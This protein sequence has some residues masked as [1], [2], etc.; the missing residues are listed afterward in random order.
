MS[1]AGL[2]ELQIRPE[3]TRRV[4]RAKEATRRWAFAS[5]SRLAARVGNER[6]TEPDEPGGVQPACVR[7]GGELVDVFLVAIVV[8][9]HSVISRQQPRIYIA[10]QP[11]P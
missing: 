8:F 11:S 5:L 6:E 2:G 7:G 4:E 3:R 9:Q 1:S 10:C